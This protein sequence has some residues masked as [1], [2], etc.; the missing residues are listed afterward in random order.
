MVM[1]K[2]CVVCEIVIGDEF[3]GIEIIFVGVF[4][5]IFLE[6]VVAFFAAFVF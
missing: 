6:E 3:V 1:L 5:D 2:G 4:M